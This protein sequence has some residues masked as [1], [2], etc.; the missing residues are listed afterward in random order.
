MAKGVLFLLLLF[1]PATSSSSSLLLL[2]H[3][4]LGICIQHWASNMYRRPVPLH[5]SSVPHWDGRATQHHGLSNCQVLSL[6]G[7]PR[8]SAGLP[9]LCCMCQTNR[10]LYYVFLLLALILLRILSKTTP[11]RLFPNNLKS[12]PF[13]DSNTS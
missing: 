3:P 5:E 6:S 1:L 11:S 4:F 8:R 9:R 2:L 13:K 7:L 12:P 10:S